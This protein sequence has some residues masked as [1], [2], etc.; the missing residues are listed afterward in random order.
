MIGVEGVSEQSLTT[1]KK[2]VMTLLRH[3]IKNF[4]TKIQ[5]FGNGFITVLMLEKNR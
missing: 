2:F 5:F 1:S 3:V 4:N